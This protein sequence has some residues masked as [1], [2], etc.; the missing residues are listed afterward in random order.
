MPPL[1]MRT[2]PYQA[3]TQDTMNTALL[4]EAITQVKQ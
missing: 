3:I 1:E 4:R 2:R